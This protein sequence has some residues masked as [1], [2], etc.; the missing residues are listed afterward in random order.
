MSNSPDGDSTVES[1]P[2]VASASADVPLS[3]G[4]VQFE[5]NSLDGVQDIL[6]RAKG[7]IRRIGRPQNLLGQPLQIAGVVALW[8]VQ[9]QIRQ[10][11]ILMRRVELHGQVEKVDNLVHL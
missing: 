11:R 7:R 5:L 6:G 3:T 1:S 9:D 4:P 2:A 10:I 8:V